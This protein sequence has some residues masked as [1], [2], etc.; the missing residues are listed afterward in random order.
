MAHYN[1]Q[2]EKFVWVFSSPYWVEFQGKASTNA[3]QGK[4]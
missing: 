4:N 3:N 2:Y 1:S